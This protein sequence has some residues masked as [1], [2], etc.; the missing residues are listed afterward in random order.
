MSTDITE[1]AAPRFLPADQRLRVYERCLLWI[2]LVIAIL[3]GLV[4]ELRSA[5]LHRRMGDVGVFLRAAW[6]VRSGHDIYHVTDANGFHYHYPPLFAILLAPLADAP[7]EATR[8][9][10]LPYAASVGVWYGLSLIF[11]VTA[12]HWLASAVEQT[13]LDPETRWSLRGSRRWWA[14]RVLPVLACLPANG[15]SLVRGQVDALLL[16]L[17][18][19][20]TAAA[21]R[22][23][24]T[25]AGVWLAGAISLKV[26]P[27]YL[28]IYPLWRRDGRWLAGTA[29]GLVAFL[30][31]IPAA[32]FGPRQTL[33]YYQEWQEVLLRPALTESG[34]QSRATELTNVTA[35]DSQS[36]LAVLHNTL[37]SDRATRPVNADRWVRLTHWGL[38]G[39]LTMLTFLS[40][41][42]RRSGGTGAVLLIGSL[43]VLMLL[44]SP[45]C[46][47]HYFS[48]MVLPITGLLA[49]SWE[50]RQSNT[51]A[52][53]GTSGTLL[54]VG[55]ILAN[56]LPRLPGLEALRDLGLA[57]YAALVLW[58]VCCF[59]LR[60]PLPTGLID[61]G[62]PPEL[63]KAA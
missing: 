52:L 38:G 18:C 50:A 4:V 21:L 45:V 37:H 6:A 29:A 59:M 53:M 24:S 35:T 9:G 5:F 14:L 61:E 15:A 20:M 7:A 28:L 30:V 41:A 11:L 43:L 16:L 44:L 25:R 2:L 27:A 42:G 19:G 54:I 31:L 40:A 56:T 46:H 12:V 57:M 1:G 13:S 23:R 34:D 39:L 10:L 62:K 47:L 63:P 36:F 58:L 60:K 8:S 17:L 49:A 55:N 22:G 3:F 32:V 48:L 51:Q 26:I 33:A